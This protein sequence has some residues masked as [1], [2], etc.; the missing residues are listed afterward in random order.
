LTALH[1]GVPVRW[2]LAPGLDCLAEVLEKFKV[3]A[4][5][6]AKA[7]VSL[8]PLLN[9]SEEGFTL[10]EGSSPAEARL[11]LGYWV[12]WR[13]GMRARVPVL[14][15]G[16][17][18]SKKGAL[19]LMGPAGSGKTTLTGLLLKM[20][21]GYLGEETVSLYGGLAHPELPTTLW[22][23]EPADPAEPVALVY[24]RFSPGEKVSLEPLEPAEAAARLLG[25]SLNADIK[26]FFPALAFV[27]KVLELRYGES[28]LAAQALAEL[29]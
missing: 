6:Q 16:G 5:P 29:L 3:D 9:G 12:R 25:C 26:C 28:Q 1:Y 8:G 2:E 7:K 17:V 22:P 19:I 11:R 24:L 10:P 13:F 20:G 21:F 4:P 15:A 18:A 27:D 14:H 23:V